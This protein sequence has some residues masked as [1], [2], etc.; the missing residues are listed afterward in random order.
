MPSNVTFIQ[1]NSASLLMT[2]VS[3]ASTIAE[4]C[5]IASTKE[6]LLD[7]VIEKVPDMK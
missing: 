7:K 2:F 3:G 5:C 1:T 6:T 4:V